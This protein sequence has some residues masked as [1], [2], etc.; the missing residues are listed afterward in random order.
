MAAFF[1]Y[2][3]AGAFLAPVLGDLHPPQGVA[4][5]IAAAVPV[6]AMLGLTVLQALLPVLASR[7]RGRAFYVHALNGFYFG[8]VA[9]RWVDRV[10]VRFANFGFRKGVQGA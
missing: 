4:A 9:D 6:A 1:L 2:Q 3:V 5:M 7:P 8:A 10:W